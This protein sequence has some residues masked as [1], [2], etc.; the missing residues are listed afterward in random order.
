MPSARWFSG[1]TLSLARHPLRHRD[2]TP[3][4]IVMSEGGYRE[5]LSHTELA[6]HA[7]G[8]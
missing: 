6:R 7:M 5:V 2:D 4:L 1:A 3:A 8:L